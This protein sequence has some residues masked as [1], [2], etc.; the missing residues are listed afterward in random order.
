MSLSNVRDLSDILKVENSFGNLDFGNLFIACHY[1][2]YEV[3]INKKIKESMTQIKI[4]LFINI[5]AIKNSIHMA[6]N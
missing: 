4:N 2:Y 5:F 1:R 6:E 3:N